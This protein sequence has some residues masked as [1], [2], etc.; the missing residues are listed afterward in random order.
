MDGIRKYPR[1]RHILDSRLQP[2]DED[3]SAATFEAIAGRHLV[4]EEKIDGANAAISFSA[5]GQ[6]LLQSRGHYLT[7][8]PRERHFALFKAWAHAIEPEL[9]PVLGSRYIVYGEWLYAKHTIFYDALPH[10]FLEFD[11]LDR[12]TGAF[13]STPMRRKLLAGLPL[14]AVPVLHE[15]KIA[16]PAALK[17]L[18]APSL[19]KSARWREVLAAAVEAGGHRAAYVD[20]QTDISD[21]AEGLYIKVEENGS[22]T[23]RFKYV[24]HDFLTAVLDS[25]SHWQSRPIL[26]NQL[27]LGVTIL[28]MS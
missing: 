22:V 4:I 15:G 26:P 16:S 12:E 19:Y 23:D 5:D 21:L 17:A 6:L 25:A 8:G 10:Y 28:G 18:I 7:G 3:L 14:A 20:K 24:R 27:R 11:V 2:G 1:T 13:L 9:R